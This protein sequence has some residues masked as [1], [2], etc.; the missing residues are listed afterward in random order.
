MGK[1]KG[2]EEEEEVVVEVVVVECFVLR[3]GFGILCCKMVRIFLTWT[4]LACDG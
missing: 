2:K 1:G 4:I 3:I